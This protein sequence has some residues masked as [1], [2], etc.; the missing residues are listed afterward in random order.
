MLVNTD[1]GKRL[2]NMISPE[3]VSLESTFDKI[4][5]AN[6]NLKLPTARPAVRDN[7]YKL[8]DELPVNEYFASH[9]PVPF[10]LKARIKSVLPVGLKVFIK[11]HK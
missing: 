3:F 6:H 5:N 11:K 4:A 7:I 1:K 8:I 2:W 9:L 10:N